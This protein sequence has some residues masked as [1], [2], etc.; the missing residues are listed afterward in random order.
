MRRLA[1]Y[2]IVIIGI[3]ALVLDFWPGLRLPSLSGSSTTNPIV[4]T[5]LGLDLK[6]GVRVEY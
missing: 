6:G 1:P 2:L 5:K 3:A 4:E